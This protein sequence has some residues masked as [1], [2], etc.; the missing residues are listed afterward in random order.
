MSKSMFNKVQRP[1]VR[2]PRAT[3]KEADAW[4][5]FLALVEEFQVEGEAMAPIAERELN[6]LAEKGNPLAI[7]LKRRLDQLTFRTREAS[8]APLLPPE[9]RR[10]TGVQWGAPGKQKKP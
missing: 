9:P 10:V 3:P 2:P 4:E 5:L 1:R 7:N 8:E 6:R